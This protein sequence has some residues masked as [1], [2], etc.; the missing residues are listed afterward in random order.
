MKLTKYLHLLKLSWQR[1][2]SYRVSFIMWRLRQFLSSLMSLTIWTVIFTSQ[3]SVFGYERNQ[4]ITYIF[5]VNVLQSL[6]FTTA[7]SGLADKI[8]S[9]D[10][11]KELVKPVNLYLYL[12]AED[13]GDKLQNFG[14]V[15]VETAILYL[16]FRPVF[17]FP[18]QL[19]VLGFFLLL[20]LGAV[21]LNF[22]ISLL[23]GSLGF[24]SP[25][26]WGPRFLFYMFVDF[27][28]GKLFPLDILP[29]AI[30]RVIYWTPFPYLS[31]VQTQLF[32]GK[33]STSQALQ[34]AGTLSLWLLIL[35]STMYFTW[36]KGIKNYSAAGQ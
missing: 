16:I 31:F 9:G 14:F 34:H 29:Q 25:Q 28:A 12:A 32:L 36:Q 15:V 30:Q 26:T 13:I 3:N 2:F 11:S 4:M 5:L 19:P 21:M 7:Q 33:I 1:T 22:F 23:F 6:I 20:T 27:T 17:A 35:G 8:Y 24:W 10:L 18:E